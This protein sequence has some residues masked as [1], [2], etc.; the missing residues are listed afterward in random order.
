MKI[1]TITGLIAIFAIALAVFFTG[2]VD[3]EGPV[4]NEGYMDVE[5]SA[6]VPE[7]T[8]G[9]ES[10]TEPEP[11]VEDE[12]VSDLNL[13]LGWAAKTS[14]ISVKVV[15]AT[16]TDHYDY[17]SDTLKQTTTEEA[18]SGKV[19]VIANMVIKKI[20][21]ES[22]YAGSSKFSMTD[23]G[24]VRYAPEPSYYGDDKLV[25]LG[26]V[27]LNQ[28]MIGGVMFEVPK[29]AKELKIWY[30]FKSLSTEIKSASWEL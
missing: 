15:S 26:E 3:N 4:D 29:D 7:L 17:Y 20:E 28:R 5:E 13:K 21:G 6:P 1:D 25:E 11:V 30:D 19:F 10:V 23:S 14:N 22:V 27:H 8:P 18:S 12:I 24:G 9:E 2:C 16:K